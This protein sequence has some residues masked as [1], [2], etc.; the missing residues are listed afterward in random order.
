MER[1]GRGRDVERLRAQVGEL[2]RLLVHL[3]L[4]R[5]DAPALAAAAEQ[6]RRVGDALAV[7]RTKRGGSFRAR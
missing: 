6:L 3:Q 2:E 7:P 5:R 4:Q 1:E